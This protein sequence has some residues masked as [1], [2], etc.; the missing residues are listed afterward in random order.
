MNENE[1]VECFCFDLVWRAS[2]F[3]LFHVHLNVVYNAIVV[4]M[5]LTKNNSKHLQQSSYN[6]T[7]R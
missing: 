3:N 4:E 6:S 1:H 7:I 5:C 2:A